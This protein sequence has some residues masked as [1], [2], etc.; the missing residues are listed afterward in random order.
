[1]YLPEIKITS[2]DDDDLW[3]K[4][5]TA[6]ASSFGYN[7]GISMNR[8]ISRYW[9][10]IINV[11]YLSSFFKFSELEITSKYAPSQSFKGWKLV[12]GVINLS[13]G[14]GYCL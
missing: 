9:R 4:V 1:M 6:A 12:F 13:I 7:L 14:I 5:N 11:D 2:S 8:E 3:I 10:F